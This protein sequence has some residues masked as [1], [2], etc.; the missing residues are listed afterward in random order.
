[1]TVNALSSHWRK[2]LVFLSIHYLPHI[3]SEMK[4]SNG[5]ITF[6][7]FFFDLGMVKL[8]TNP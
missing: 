5:P 8:L 1:M 3:M 6:N 7:N 4:I 2:V